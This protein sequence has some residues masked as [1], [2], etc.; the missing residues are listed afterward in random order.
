MYPIELLR[1]HFSDS[2]L[3]SA[4]TNKLISQ[5]GYFYPHQ[6]IEANQLGIYQHSPAYRQAV[7]EMLPDRKT[8]PFKNTY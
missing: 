7:S 2:A 5:S 4:K 6:R 1:L 8:N 3:T